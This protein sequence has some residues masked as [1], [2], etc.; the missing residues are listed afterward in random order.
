MSQQRVN[1]LERFYAVADSTDAHLND[2]ISK[3]DSTVASLHNT[4]LARVVQLEKA[5]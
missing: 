5:T 3:Y 1:K 4:D 2:L